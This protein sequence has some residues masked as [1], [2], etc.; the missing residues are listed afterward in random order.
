MG[1]RF[2][3][4]AIP[5][6][7]KGLPKPPEKIGRLREASIFATVFLYNGKALK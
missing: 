3:S 4:G 6:A 2:K 7:V 5:V 1:I